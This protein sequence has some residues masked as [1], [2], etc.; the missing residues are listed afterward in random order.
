MRIVLLA[1]AFLLV[2][3]ARADASCIAAIKWKG[4]WYQG[5][6]APQKP[7]ERLSPQ[8]I[9]PACNDAGQN[10]PDTKTT[11]RRVPG[12]N[13]AVAVASGQFVWVSASTFTEQEDHPL[14]GKLG[15]RHGQPAPRTGKR[16]TVTGSATPGLGGVFGLREH[17]N[18]PIDV[19]VRTKISLRR[20]GTAFIPHGTKVRVKGRCHTDRLLADRIDAARRSR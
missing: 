7:G 1:A 14:Y 12:I 6:S 10:D 18:R 19:D 16:C 8:A 9:V 5:F 17:K 4:A 15:Y 2:L 13:P 11:V 20:H 3:A